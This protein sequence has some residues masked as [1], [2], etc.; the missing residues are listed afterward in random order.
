MRFCAVTILLLLC[1][2]CAFGKTHEIRN[3]EGIQN[4]RAYESVYSTSEPT[5]V[6]EIT[7]A[8]WNLPD[9]AFAFGI[10]GR[11]KWVK[12]DFYNPQP[13]PLKRF[14]Y[15]PYHHIH[16][17]DVYEKTDSVIR[18]ISKTG[19][20]RH[21]ALKS[22]DAR[23]YPIK[24]Y[25]PS[26]HSSIIFKYD[27]VNL[28]LRTS[29]FL[30]TGKE[31]KAT[32]AKNKSIIWFWK[33][34]F[35]MAL[36]FSLLLYFSSHI[37]LFLYYFL[38]NLGVAFFIGSDIG[39]FMNLLDYDIYNRI[40]DLKQFGNVLLL[41]FF[42][43]FLNELTPIKHFHPKIWK[44]M[45]YGIYFTIVL[46]IITLFNAVK[47]SILLWFIT[48]YFIIFSSIVF[49][50]Q[51]YLLVL[52]TLKKQKNGWELLIIYGM[53][54]FVVNLSIILPNM[55]IKRD[56]LFAYNF[57][58]ISSIGEILIFL[59]LMGT[60]A[61][62][63]FTDHNSLLKKQQKHQKEIINAIVESQE[64][65]RNKIGGEM[66]DRIGANIA[67]I[68]HNIDQSNRPIIHLID[69]T[70]DTIRSISH[71]LMTPRVHNGD[72]EEEIKNL[73]YLSSDEKM[74]VKY[75][76]HQ[77]PQLNASE[78]PT[79]LYRIV[80]E[81]LQNASKHSE[82]TK[83]HVQFL[84]RENDISLLYEDNGKGLVYDE[85]R[86]EGRG[87]IGIEN[88]VQLING[89]LHVDSGLNNGLSVM[90]ELKINT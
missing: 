57:V 54:I 17:I 9:K 28:P 51:L 82:A 70:I 81:L 53:Y 78:V 86:K 76:F 88:R 24:V 6:N 66:H 37:K 71:G 87:L 5:Y 64:L 31:V 79:H 40:L 30:M 35:F 4:L 68:R 13:I 33:G 19:T 38:L 43:L 11:V 80:Q 60:N 46:L 85:S 48:Y 44:I 59:F 49:L 84:K 61:I 25:L 55:G 45:Y 74:K 23:G 67:L 39:D 1:I 18:V 63:V 69:D 21:A 3:G 89:I 34:V 36:L 90:I 73:C 83:V 16:K 22:L 62:R 8:D 32:I 77:W 26:G 10:S 47:T 72:F 56:G 75:Y 65:E 58:L 12:Y 27:H 15:V 20:A 52:A 42:P 2:F 7:E 50:W 29:A 41:F 14:I